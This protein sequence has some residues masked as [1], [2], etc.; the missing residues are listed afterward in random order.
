LDFELGSTNSSQVELRAVTVG[1]TPKKLTFGTGLLKDLLP[2]WQVFIGGHE[3]NLAA[4]GSGWY[5]WPD[6]APMPTYASLLNHGDYYWGLG[7]VGGPPFDGNYALAFENV[8]SESNRAIMVRQTG[9]I[10]VEARF[11]TL[12]HFW[13]F[14]H[15]TFIISINGQ[16]HYLSDLRQNPSDKT[17]RAL[18]ISAWAGKTATLEFFPFSDAA[19][20]IDSIALVPALD[21]LLLIE[22]NPPVNGGPPSV[23]LIFGVEDGHDYF[24]EFRDGMDAQPSWQVLPGSPHNSGSVVDSAAGPQRFYRLRSEVT[25]P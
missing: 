1:L 8:R 21:W 2:G 10:P 6:L 14:G 17:V 24:V 20:V 4:V 18:E 15:G 22:R 23:T 3:T 11:L 12:R 25:T 5:Q 13:Q 7:G 19:V 16:R 9:D